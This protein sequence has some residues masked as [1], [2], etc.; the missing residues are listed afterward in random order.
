[1]A[2][3]QAKLMLE[4]KEP[5]RTCGLEPAPYP[6]PRFF[7]VLRHAPINGLLFPAP[8]LELDTRGSLLQ[9]D[10]YIVD[11]AHPGTVTASCVA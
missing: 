8:H 10:Q 4:A 5:D 11:E 1:M 7:Q 6:A 2:L 9:H 3:H